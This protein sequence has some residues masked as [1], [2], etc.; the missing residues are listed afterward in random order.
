MH[1]IGH[2]IDLV[3]NARIGRMLDTHGRR[4]VER[5]FTENEQ[6][7]AESGGRRRVERYAARFA[8]K[9]AVMKVL[10]TGWRAGMAWRDIEVVR[11]PSGQPAVELTGRTAAIADQLGITDWRISLSHTDDCS[12]ASVL[13]GTA[14]PDAARHESNQ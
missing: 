8:C 10:G 2:G 7:Y 4:F 9:E 5:C 11:L 3:N 1:V 6:T 12:V 13:G 14:C